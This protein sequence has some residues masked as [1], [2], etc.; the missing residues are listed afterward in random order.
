M[1]QPLNLKSQ[2]R[3]KLG[4]GYGKQDEGASSWPYQRYRPHNKINFPTISDE[5]PQGWILK[6]EKYFRYY[7]IL[8]EE[9]VDVASMH[10]EGDALEFYSWASTN[11]TMEYFE[12]LVRTLK[13]LE[14]K[15]EPDE[16]PTDEIDYIARDAN[17]VVKISLH[18]ILGKAHLRTM[19]VQGILQSTSKSYGGCVQ[20]SSLLIFLELL[21][22]KPE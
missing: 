1:W 17:D 18:V 7:N 10:L 11:Q 5:D 4:N 9:K 13:V 15:E 16:Q 14:V 21:S 8:E 22:C 20:P 3:D 6:A 2:N 12:D 19:K